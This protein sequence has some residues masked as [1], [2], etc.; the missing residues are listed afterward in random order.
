MAI[1]SWISTSGR[2]FN[3]GKKAFYIVDIFGNYTQVVLTI[4]GYVAPP[5]CEIKYTILN[6]DTTADGV[7]VYF[8]IT[9]GKFVDNGF[10]KETNGGIIKNLY[11]DFV[12][13]SLID[14]KFVADSTYKLKSFK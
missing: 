4:N 7:D 5:A 2:W 3:S 14:G 11:D 6:K 8:E 13:G 9:S 1:F 10:Y 12:W